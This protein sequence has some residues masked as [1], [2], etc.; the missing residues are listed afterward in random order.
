MPSQRFLQTNHVWLFRGNWESL[1]VKWSKNEWQIPPATSYGFQTIAIVLWLYLYSLNVSLWLKQR[2]VLFEA[3]KATRI[4]DKRKVS[5]TAIFRRSCI[6]QRHDCKEVVHR[7]NWFT[8]YTL[9]LHNRLF[10]GY[11]NSIIVRFDCIRTRSILSD[12]T[13]DVNTGYRTHS[14]QI[15]RETKCGITQKREAQFRFPTNIRNDI[16]QITHAKDMPL[17]LPSLQQP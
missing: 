7:S 1:W 5:Y 4:K 12:L 17:T 11:Q 6:E 14:R 8:L 13:E 9:L 10:N 2:E 3:N 15:M 16:V